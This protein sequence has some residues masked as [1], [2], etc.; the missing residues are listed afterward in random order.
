MPPSRFA[1]P[2][3]GRIVLSF[4]DRDVSIDCI[5]DKAVEDFVPKFVTF[6]SSRVQYLT[7]QLLT[8]SID[9]FKL[10]TLAFGV[11]KEHTEIASG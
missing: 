7:T 10:I 9:V 11:L 2:W 8:L 4:L 5:K 1:K 6:G 3:A